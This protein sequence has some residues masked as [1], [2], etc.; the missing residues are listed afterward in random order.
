[1]NV[2][3]KLL[4]ISINVF[5]SAEKPIYKALTGISTIAVFALFQWRIKPYRYA[6]MNE[7]EYREMISSVIL[8]S[9][10]VLT[11]QMSILYGGIIFLRED[12]SL[13]FK[14]AIFVL[15]AY[16]ML[17]FV[18]LW[19]R[20]FAE[21]FTKYRLVKALTPWLRRLSTYAKAS[22]HIQLPEQEEDAPA[23]VPPSPSADV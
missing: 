11:L 8:S 13:L 20:A 4:L 5:F 3:R 6:I 2:L 9:H 18:V 19:T 15:I 12:A 14:V 23:K 7:I 1:M 16:Y 10:L 17:S 22:D 21:L